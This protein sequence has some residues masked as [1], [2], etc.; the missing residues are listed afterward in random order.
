MFY[1]YEFLVSA[2]HMEAMQGDY[3]QLSRGMRMHIVLELILLHTLY[4][5]FRHFSNGIIL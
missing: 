4:T 5:V 3:P 2:E 1:D